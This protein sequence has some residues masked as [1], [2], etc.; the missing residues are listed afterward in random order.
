MQKREQITELLIR[1]SG[2]DKEALDIL[3]PLVYDEL[4]IL[5]NNYLRNE[6]NH[7]L[8]PTIIV[9]EVYLRLVHQE[10][11]SFESRA[12]FFAMVA[13]L[14]R[15]ILVDRVRFYQAAKRGGRQYNITLGEA[16]KLGSKP[17][18]DLVLLNDLLNSLSEIRPEYGQI[19]ELRFFGGLTIEE[20]AKVLGLSPTT[21]NRNWVFAKT[22]LKRELTKNQEIDL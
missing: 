21:V 11:I 15:N 3:M 9:H 16:D 5:A 19:V 12:Q 2:G 22:W 7:S 18:I 17:D 1:W 14:V 4:H 10:R 6:Q 13:K 20:T 8:Q